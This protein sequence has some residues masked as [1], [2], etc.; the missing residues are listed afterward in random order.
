MGGRE[1]SEDAKMETK[2][3]ER[4]RYGTE[5]RRCMQERID[6]REREQKKEKKTKKRRGEGDRSRKCE[7]CGKNGEDRKR[8]SGWR[9]MLN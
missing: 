8:R 9:V 1:R 7:G 6:G 3:K 4:K 5:M 2:R